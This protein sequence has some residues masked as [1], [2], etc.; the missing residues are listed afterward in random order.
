M[1]T[2]YLVTYSPIRGLKGQKKVKEFENGKMEEAMAYGWKLAENNKN[3]EYFI[4]TEYN[5]C[6]KFN[7]VIII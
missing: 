2:I 4:I 6:F 3:N 5:N 1:N 7:R